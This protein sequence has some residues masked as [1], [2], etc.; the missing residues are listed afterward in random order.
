MHAKTVKVTAVGHFFSAVTAASTQGPCV[1]AGETN[2]KHVLEPIVTGQHT[3]KT[4]TE[5]QQ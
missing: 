2:V 5:L 3:G 4:C 1:V